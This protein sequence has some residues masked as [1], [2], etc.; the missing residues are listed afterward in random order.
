[1]TQASGF[2]LSTL[3]TLLTP[4]D[5]FYVRDHFRVPNLKASSWSLQV[6]GHVRSHLEISYSDLVH[7]PS[8]TITATLGCAGKWGWRWRGQHCLLDRCISPSTAPAC[9]LT[10]GE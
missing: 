3:Q 7:M 5:Q 1:M 9:R 6:N 8:R 2:D 4:N 10:K